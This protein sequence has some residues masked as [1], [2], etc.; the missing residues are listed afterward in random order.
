[1]RSISA[2]E[3]EHGKKDRRG[4][5]DK[6]N[7]RSGGGGET[8]AQEEMI[9]A[10]RAGARASDTRYTADAITRIQKSCYCAYFSRSCMIGKRN[11]TINRLRYDISMY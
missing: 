6:R 2:F 8:V 11:I 7:R 4:K 3:A 10:R 1:L 5:R 9:E